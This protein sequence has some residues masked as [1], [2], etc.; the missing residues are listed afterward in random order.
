MDPK[1]QKASVESISAFFLSIFPKA[2]PVRNM[3]KT[4]KTDVNEWAM[5]SNHFSITLFPLSFQH[6]SNM[7]N[8]IGQI[9]RVDSRYPSGLTDRFWS[10]SFQFLPCLRGEILDPGITNF[11]GNFERLH[12]FEMP[13]FF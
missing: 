4:G 10:D 6:L 11:P 5:R 1:S 2:Y 8:D 12:F 3:R 13:D 7:I 9:S